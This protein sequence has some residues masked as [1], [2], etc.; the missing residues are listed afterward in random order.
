[1]A[2]YHAT[3]KPISRSAG[4]SSVAAAAYR[5]AS[6]LTDQRTGQRHDYTRKGGV[7]SAKVIMPDGSTA[8]R[9]D[10]W[11][12]AEA[13][14]RRKDARTAREWEVALPAELS[15]EQRE[16]LA[17]GFARSLA[18]RYGVAADCAIHAPGG[19][20][21]Q[22]NH[23]AHILLTT[24]QVVMENGQI[25]MGPK[26]DLEMDN[27][28]RAQRGLPSSEQQIKDIR[29]EWADRQN[30]ALEQE[31]SAERVDHRSHA[32]RGIEAEPGR[33]LGP[34][35]TALQRELAAVQQA[36]GEARE[37]LKGIA[38][39][40]ASTAKS[41]VRGIVDRFREANQGISSGEPSQGGILAGLREQRQEGG[42][43][44]DRDS[45]AQPA[46]QAKDQEQTL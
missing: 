16:E 7:E 38:A 8:D 27:K 32:E 29:K 43:A 26:S 44:Q 37:I 21:D 41:A 25:V 19:K 23:H 9:S 2:I 36:L 3:T 10:L 45:A 1:M 24:R 42:V 15:Q 13:A 17:Q 11:N 12:A 35:G 31:Q 22:R 14:E 33:H 28:Q 39:D 40:I 20:G 18:E 34:A 5:S 4:R 30:S 46:M 6:D